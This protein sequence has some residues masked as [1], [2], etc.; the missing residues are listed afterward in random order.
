MKSMRFGKIQRETI[1]ELQKKDK[2]NLGTLTRV[3]NIQPSEMLRIV[4]S[5]DN[6][7]LIKN[8]QGTLYYR[9]DVREKNFAKQD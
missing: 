2:S 8:I 5:I 7:R 1:L 9:G 3:F 6:K 4:E